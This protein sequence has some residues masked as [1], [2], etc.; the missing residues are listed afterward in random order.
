MNTVKFI[1]S[2]SFIFSPRPGTPASD[3]E[4]IDEKVA[5]ERLAIFQNMAEEIKL[6]YKKKTFK[7][8]C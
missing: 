2:Y 6:N 3:M 8:S 7:P 5:R 1:N 4:I